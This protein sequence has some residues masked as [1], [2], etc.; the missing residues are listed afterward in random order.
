MKRIFTFILSLFIQS[1]SFSQG[2]D[3]LSTDYISMNVDSL[4]ADSMRKEFIREHIPLTIQEKNSIV[5]KITPLHY[6]KYLRHHMEAAP[7]YATFKKS[8]RLYVSR[9]IPPSK[10]WVL[11][12]FM[13]LLLFSAYLHSTDREYVKNVFRVYF[14]EGFIF[15]Q[16]KDQLLQARISSLFLNFLFV[17]SFAVYFFFGVGFAETAVGWERWYILGVSIL[18]IVL[19]YAFK[20][21]FLT[22]MGWLFDARDSF[23]SYIFIVF[24][25]AKVAGMLMLVASMIIAVSDQSDGSLLFKWVGFMLMGMII[26]RSFK[27]FKLFSREINLPAY[28]IAC[29]ALEI[30]PIAVLYK[31]LS[32]SY[33]LLFQGVM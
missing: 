29:I 19:I 15:R 26:F 28:I 21:I 6:G 1:I 32:E 8:S 14:N 23:E 22:F 18:L 17:F 31:F 13:T 2:Q 11:Y 20:F 24:L 33:E 27:G 30:L 12:L 25:N 5:L 7:W 3:S 16:T 10:E 9:R 4:I